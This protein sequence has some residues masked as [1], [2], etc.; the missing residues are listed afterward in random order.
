M[1]ILSFQ[2]DDVEAWNSGLA[3]EKTDMPNPTKGLCFHPG[4]Q[5]LWM[6]CWHHEGLPSTSP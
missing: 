5:F 2:F 4:L 3:S 1:T 6:A